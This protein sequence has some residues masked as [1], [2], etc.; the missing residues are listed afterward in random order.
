MKHKIEVREKGTGAILQ[1]DE[2]EG[3]VKIIVAPYTQIQAVVRVKAGED[4][5]IQQAK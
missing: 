4:G 2:V 1:R 3:P 5:P